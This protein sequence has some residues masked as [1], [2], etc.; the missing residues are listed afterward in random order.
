MKRRAFLGLL[1]ATTAS[2]LAPTASANNTIRTL[3]AGLSPATALPSEEA[4]RFIVFGDSGKGDTAQ[5]ELARMMVAHHWSQFY[6]TALML[7]DNI[8]PDGN[9]ED[10]QAKFERPYA[11]LLRRGVTFHAVLGNHDVKKGREAQI[12]YR[13]FNMGGRA[14][15]SFTKGDGLVEFFGIDSNRFDFL[16]RRWLEEALQASQAKW[17]I[18]MFHHPLYSS[19]DKHGSDFHLR[20]ELEPLLIKYGVDAA[21]SGHDHVYERTKPQQGV[22][23]FTSGAGAKT[24]HGDLQR[25]TPFHVTGA[26][27]TSSFMSIELTPERFSFK[28]INIAG[29][30]IDSGEL[31]P[32]SAAR[33]ATLIR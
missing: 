2:A 8:Y 15:Y 33:A 32:R 3:G 5:H 6:D 29:R 18:A 23:Y 20:A 17:K 19:A 26:D 25:G 27:E 1:S 9:P 31:A 24:R 13:N 10:I 16:Q 28:T 14:Y 7:G 30:E 4:L 21:F 11:E 12:N 22:Q